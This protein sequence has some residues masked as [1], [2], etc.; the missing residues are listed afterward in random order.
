MVSMYFIFSET[1]RLFLR[2]A[3]HF[4]FPPAEQEIQFLHILT[5][6]NLLPQVFTLAILL[7]EHSYQNLSKITW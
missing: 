1:G 6:A 2:E 7:G 3:T 5:G 4:T